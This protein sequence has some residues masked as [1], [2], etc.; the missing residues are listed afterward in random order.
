MTMSLRL[1]AICLAFLCVFPEGGQGA[2]R[3]S[4]P[5]KVDFNRDVRPIF[6]ENCYACHGPDKNKR[7]ADLRLD[8]KEGLTFSHDDVVTVVPGHPEKSELF[9]RVTTDDPDE[10]MPDPKSTK[11]L[12]T[13]E[14]AVLKKWIEQGAE[15][16]GHW[17]FIKPVRPD[18]PALDWPG[19]VRN[20][21]D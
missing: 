13:R 5:D 19:F 1:F 16:K 18:V 10:R 3:K 12:T 14:I 17:A 2:A 20:D 6:S 4:A 8:T 7:K 11:R 21:V 9:R 15:Y